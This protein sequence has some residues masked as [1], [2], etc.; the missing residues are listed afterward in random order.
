MNGLFFSHFHIAVHH[1]R[2]SGQEVTQYKNLKAAADEEAM[3]GASYI[4]FALLAFLQ[5]IV[6]LAQEWHHSPWYGSCRTYYLLRQCLILGLL[7]AF[8]YLRLLH[9]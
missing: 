8:P 4:C 6:L 2:K 9:L 5:N 3:V 1:Q 7:K